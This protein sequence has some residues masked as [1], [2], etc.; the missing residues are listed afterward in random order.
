M[1]F[2][3]TLHVSCRKYPTV[4]HQNLAFGISIYGRST[5]ME[6]RPWVDLNHQ[7]FG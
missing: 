4:G 1:F 7:R 2:N 6:K 5:E 3:N